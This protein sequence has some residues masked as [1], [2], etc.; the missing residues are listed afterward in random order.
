[1]QVTK[2]ERVGQVVVKIN[3]NFTEFNDNVAD[4]L[5]FLDFP[6]REVIEIKEPTKENILSDDDSI[7]LELIDLVLGEGLVSK[8]DIK[9]ELKG[10]LA[11]SRIDFLLKE[12]KGKY[13]GYKKDEDEWK[14]YMIGGGS[15]V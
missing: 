15:D 2:I 4:L 14:V 3:V 10:K 9:I 12:Y 7:G 11:S 5:A 6:V 1:M 13:F 8:K